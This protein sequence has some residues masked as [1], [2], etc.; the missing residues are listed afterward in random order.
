MAFVLVIVTGLGVITI[1]LIFGSWTMVFLLLF[2]TAAV[3]YQFS[4]KPRQTNTEQTQGN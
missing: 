2:V 3:Y 1:R 4:Y